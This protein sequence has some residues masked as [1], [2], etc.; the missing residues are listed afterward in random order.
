LGTFTGFVDVIGPMELTV[1]RENQTEVLARATF[2]FDVSPKA[3][4][5]GR[6]T[7]RT[8]LATTT[9]STPSKTR[10]HSDHAKLPLANYFKIA[11]FTLI[12]P[13]QAQTIYHQRSAG[14]VKA[15]PAV[16]PAP[17]GF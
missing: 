4:W 2:M 7:G 1:W 15:P 17:R 8:S 9:A 14:I 13:R 12:A 11:R 5:C 16:Q 10:P 3:A 6:S